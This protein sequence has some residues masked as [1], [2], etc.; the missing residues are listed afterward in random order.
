MVAMNLHVHVH[1]IA[2]EISAS[3]FLSFRYGFATSSVTS[4]NWFICVLT[5]VIFFFLYFVAGNATDIIVGLHALSLN[6]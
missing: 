4:G 3:I 1:S 5:Q 2:S 6:T